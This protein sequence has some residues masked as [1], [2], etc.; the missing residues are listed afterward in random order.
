MT[1][2]SDPQ[3]RK[4]FNAIRSIVYFCY[5]KHDVLPS[6]KHKKKNADHHYLLQI[7]KDAC[8]ECIPVVDEHGCSSHSYLA[9]N[10][11]RDNAKRVFGKGGLTSFIFTEFNKTGITHS[12]YWEKQNVEERYHCKDNDFVIR[13]E[14]EQLKWYSDVED[15]YSVIGERFRFSVPWSVL[16]PIDDS[17][18]SNICRLLRNLKKDVNSENVETILEFA[19][20]RIGFTP[21]MYRQAVTRS[22]L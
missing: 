6:S 20:N 8:Y 15:K 3:D 9:I 13:E 4:N 1:V 16:L 7:L 12:E 2:N 21:T 18:Y 17:M 19:V 10:I 14:S 5:E 22:L 11:S